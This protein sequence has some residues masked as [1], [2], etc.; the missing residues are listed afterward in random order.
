MSAPAP[1][2]KLKNSYIGGKCAW[3][4]LFL[5]VRIFFMFAALLKKKLKWKHKTM[6]LGPRPAITSHLLYRCHLDAITVELADEK[7]HLHLSFNFRAMQ[8][9]PT[10]KSL[11]KLNTH[12]ILNS[13]SVCTLFPI[14]IVVVVITNISSLLS[15]QT[16][17]FILLELR[18]TV[19]MIQEGEWG[20]TLDSCVHFTLQIVII[21][22]C[23]LFD[24]RRFF[25][26]LR[27]YSTLNSDCNELV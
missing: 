13:H 1:H 12:R 2:L 7:H 27:L 6:R 3:S 26:E 16:F 14:I 11:K 20:N 25:F 21:F 9:A 8:I 5:F 17:F 15:A 4:A 23:S 22:K 24:F 18:A 10:G 19:L